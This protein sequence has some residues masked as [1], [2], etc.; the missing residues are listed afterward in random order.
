MDPKF[1]Q[2]QYVRLHQNYENRQNSTIIFDR[3]ET[4]IIYYRS[5]FESIPAIHS[6]G[7]SRKPPNR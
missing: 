7:G 6:Y 4:L 1:T 5:E 3:L 2:L